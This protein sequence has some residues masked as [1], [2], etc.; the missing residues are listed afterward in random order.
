MPEIQVDSSERKRAQD[1]VEFVRREMEQLSESGR[2]VLVIELARMI[3][4]EVNRIR[5]NHP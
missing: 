2:T 5:G 4:P 1:I 3:M